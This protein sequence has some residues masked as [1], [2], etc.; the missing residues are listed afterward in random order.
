MRNFFILLIT[1]FTSLMLTSLP[2]Y[3]KIIFP[4]PPKEINTASGNAE[5]T[6]VFSGGCF[7][8][9]EGVFEKLIGVRTVLSGYSGGDSSTAHYEIVSRGN[10]GHA[11]SVKIFYNPKVISY[12][13][14][15]K[16]FFSIAHNPTELNYQG[17]DEGTQYRSVIFYSNNAQKE[18][19]ESYVKIIDKAKVFNK[20]IVT[21][22]VPLK[23]FYPAEDYHQQFLRKN[24]DYPYIVMWDLPK[25]KALEAEY[26]SLVKKEG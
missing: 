3:G 18:T 14:L 13:T 6:A 15:L 4:E 19:A 2:V 8:G 16:V 21:Q 10:T 7:W 1:V 17:P 26:P 20:P 24:P 11:E 12:G 22:I 9:V 25:I 23:S 5:E